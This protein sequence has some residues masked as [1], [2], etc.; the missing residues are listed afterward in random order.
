L[1]T[2]PAPVRLGLVP[3]LARPGANAAGVEVPPTLLDRA[4]EVIK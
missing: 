3:S 4:D 1:F 2:R